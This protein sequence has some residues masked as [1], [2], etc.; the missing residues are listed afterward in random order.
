MAGPDAARRGAARP[1]RA[2]PATA[3]SH[4]ARLDKGVTPLA[5][6]K[7]LEPHGQAERRLEGWGTPGASRCPPTS[8]ST[9]AR[10]PC[11]PPQRSFPSCPAAVSA[12]PRTG[13]KLR[14]PATRLLDVRWGAGPG[15]PG[16]GRAAGCRRRRGGRGARSACS[17]EPGA[18]PAGSPPR[19]GSRE[20]S[21]RG[22]RKEETGGG[23][24]RWGGRRGGRA[25]GLRVGGRCSSPEDGRAATSPRP[26]L[27][28]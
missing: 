16:G 7:A 4:P 10:R 18:A 21:E 20:E 17:L 14:P 13:G 5:A 26:R 8:C 22:W 6:L 23:S 25:S 9:R 27:P 3:L 28:P 19:Q 15:G 2:Q 1:A 24:R 11:S 12:Q